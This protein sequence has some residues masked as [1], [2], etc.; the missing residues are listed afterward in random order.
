[1]GAFTI[2]YDF[3]REA[4]LFVC[5]EHIEPYSVFAAVKKLKDYKL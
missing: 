5:S 1:M 4:L 3:W 2:I